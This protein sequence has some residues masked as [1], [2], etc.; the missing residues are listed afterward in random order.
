[1]YLPS[2]AAS[3]SDAVPIQPYGCVARQRKSLI[4]DFTS[5]AQKRKNSREVSDRE[6]EN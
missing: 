1:M 6:R 3:L 2:L 5:P 4:I